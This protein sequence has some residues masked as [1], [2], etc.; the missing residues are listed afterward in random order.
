MYAALI[1][2]AL[3]TR[4]RV[5]SAMSCE[6]HEFDAREGGRVRVSLTYDDAGEAGKTSAHT[7][8]YT[9]W[10]ELLQPDR[11]VVEVDVFETDDPAL[12][13]ALRSTIELVPVADGTELIAVHEDLPPGLDPAANEAGWNEALDRLAALVESPG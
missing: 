5:P 3:V 6:V 12:Q 8:T 7:D 10:F 13:G 11:V 9:G 2:P 1:D 4:W